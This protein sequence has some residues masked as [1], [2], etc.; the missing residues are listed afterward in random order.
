M[1]LIVVGTNHKF[2]PIELR[3]RLVFPKKR[4][5]N[6]LFLLKEWQIF[7]GAVILSTCNRMEIYA[8][9][10]NLESAR[11]QIINFLSRY[12]E[13]ETKNFLPY[14][15]TYEA[16]EALRHLFAVT[17][18]LDSLILG[19]TQISGQVKQAYLEAREIGF[20]DEFLR[21]TFIQAL[22]FAKMIHKET[23][24][25]EGKISVGSLALDFIKGRLGNLSS[26]NI[27]IIGVGKVS[28]LVLQY[29]KKE[30]PNVIFVSNRTFEKAK[31]LASEINGAAVRFDRLRE[32][33]K[34]ADVVI[35]A[36]ASPHF[37]I[38]KE[39][40]E[41][42]INHGLLIV[43]LAL[44]RNVEPLVKDIMGVEL[45]CLEDLGTVIKKNFEKKKEEAKKIE[46][47]IKIKAE[48]LW[49]KLTVLEPEPA[50][51]RLSR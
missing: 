50:F 33:L 6:A 40:L 4:L 32:S 27:L 42:L 30:R 26:K 29:L 7:K 39:T 2:S 31:A 24:I 19:E 36:T 37:I 34:K 46:E 45:F 41:G 1:N 15:Y 22:S 8:S 47:V 48:R 13:I 21:K 43:D 5:K 49:Q 23:K 28:E 25:S 20:A 11:G 3:E 18:G 14:L 51:L 12:H 38:K 16:K 44:P 10:E 9:T 17:C 35:T